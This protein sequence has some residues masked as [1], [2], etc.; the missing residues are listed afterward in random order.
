M[1]SGPGVQAA[2][3]DIC[4]KT[5]QAF[6]TWWVRVLWKAGPSGCSIAGEFVKGAYGWPA[7]SQM[8]YRRTG[9]RIYGAAGFSHS[10]VQSA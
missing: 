8:C 10:A 1:S 6:D 5:A 7:S 3:W 9:L 4:N 2:L